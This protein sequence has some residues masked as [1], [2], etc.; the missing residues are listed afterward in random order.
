MLAEMWAIKYWKAALNFVTDFRM[1]GLEYI[2]TGTLRVSTGNVLKMNPEICTLQ[3][4]HGVHRP[5]NIWLFWILY[6]ALP[7]P[8]V[9]CVYETAQICSGALYLQSLRVW[10]KSAKRFQNYTPKRAQKSS[11]K[12][13]ILLEQ[14]TLRPLSTRN[15]YHI[16]FCRF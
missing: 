2:N 4:W 5:L 13:G 8:I 11:K 3:I 6:F 10:A 1:I 15:Q 16:D 14:P 12:W 9:L 7:S